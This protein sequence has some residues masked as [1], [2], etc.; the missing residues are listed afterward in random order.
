MAAT[1][2]QGTILV[3]DDEIKNSKL[4]EALLAPRGYKIFKAF[5]GKEAVDR[6]KEHSPDLILMDVM[7]PVLN[8]FEAC[9]ILKEQ[10]ETRHIPVVFM[11]ALGQVEDRVKGLD[12]G[13]DD[14]LTKPV[15]RDELMARIRTSIRQKKVM[16]E[17][18]SL[19]ESARDHLTKFVPV[20]VQRRIA[21][22]PVSPDLEKKKQD[23]SVLF[24]DIT[25]YTKL[26]ESLPQEQIAFIVESLFSGFIDVIDQNGGEV[27]STAG[28]GMMVMF[29]DEDP[30]R[31]AHSAVRTA[32]EFLAMTRQLDDQPDVL[33][34]IDTGHEPI[35][36]HIGINSGEASVGPARFEGTVGTHWTYTA[37]GSAVNV[38]ARIGALAQAGMALVSQETADRVR[39]VFALK[40][41]G[42]RE[43]KNVSQ[44]IT[45]YEVTGTLG[46]P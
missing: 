37:V 9:R 5:N 33:Q 16:D 39:D 25:G 7:M 18:I 40:E 44:P 2:S 24:V 43:F 35:N 26:S 29:L 20:S 17:R 36:I 23:M 8:G 42:P 21:Q 4:I 45:I 19:L 22:N 6:A 3:V 38:A 28:D 32:L 12:A 10:P 15:N 1:E 46:G 30:V 13:G 11:T 14:F 27:G 34:S 31:N 41:I